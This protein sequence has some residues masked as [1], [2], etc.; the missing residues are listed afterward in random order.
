[1]FLDFGK[2]RPQRIARPAGKRVVTVFAIQNDGRIITAHV[3]F[4]YASNVNPN[5]LAGP[6][7]TRIAAET[8]LQLIIDEQEQEEG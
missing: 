5:W 4:K 1:M 2:R 3:P 7:K 6:F 8:E